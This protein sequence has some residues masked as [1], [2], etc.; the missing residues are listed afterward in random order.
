MKRWFLPYLMLSPFL[1]L[2]VLFYVIPAFITVI[3]AFTDMNYAMEWRF[4]GLANFEKIFT[5]PFLPVIVWNTCKYVGGTLFFNVVFGFVLALLSTYYIQ[6]EKSGIFFRALWMLPRI[7]PPVVYVLLFLWFFAPGQYG[8]LNALSAIFLGVEPQNWLSEYAM[9]IVILA[10]GLVGA[11]FGMI[12]FSS[13]IRAIPQDI[14]RAAKVDGATEFA[15]TKEIILPLM[16]WPV[17]FVSVWQLLSLLTSFE[18]I[19]LLTGGGP[20]LD[21]E[22]WSLYS[23]HRAFVGFEFGYGAALAL[24]MVFTAFFLTALMLKLF[25]FNRM[26]KSSRID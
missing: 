9:L 8:L 2:V 19:L 13:A 17:M 24:V 21:T 26:I 23:Y 11:S 1:I 15:I 7:S 3:L 10:N 14:F 12:I 25:D 22:V 5:D 20:F 18:Y 16:K 4:A 6:H